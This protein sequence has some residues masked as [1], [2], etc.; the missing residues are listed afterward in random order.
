MALIKNL[1]SD[2]D[3]KRNRFREDF[4]KLAIESYQIVDL[5]QRVEWWINKKS[6]YINGLTAIDIDSSGH[7]L[8]NTS[9]RGEL[10]LDGF[11]QNEINRLKSIIELENMKKEIIVFTGDEIKYAD[12]DIDF[13]GDTQKI[14]LLIELGIFDYIKEKY[15]TNSDAQLCK[16]IHVISGIPFDNIRKCYQGYKSN[17]DIKRYDKN[18]PFNSEKNITHY[19]AT[20]IKL[21]IDK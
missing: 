9:M 7:T 12:M 4:E 6:D 1:L 14:G 13:D 11:I 5:Y 8:Q 19:K 10:Y 16:I 21:G 2:Y 17:K 3:K 20:K 15:Q 18:N